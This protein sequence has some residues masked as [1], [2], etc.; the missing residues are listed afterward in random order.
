MLFLLFLNY[1]SSS[2][3]T[4]MTALNFVV[5]VAMTIKN[6]IQFVFT[7]VELHSETVCVCVC[8]GAIDQA[9]LKAKYVL[10]RTI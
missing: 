7:A 4:E 8:G 3:C 5:L 9:A 1:L 10:G 2:I 6:S